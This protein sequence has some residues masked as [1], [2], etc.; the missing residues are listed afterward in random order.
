MASDLLLSLRLGPVL[1]E[2]VPGPVVDAL[3]EVQVTEGLGQPGG[4]QLTFSTGKDSMVTRELLPSGALDP[5]ARVQVVLTVRGRST[6][7]MDGVITRHELAPSSVPGAGRLTVTG[8]DVSRMMDVI[9]FSGLPYVGMPPEARVALICAKYVL[10][11]LVPVIVPSVFI[12]TPNPLD[13]IP[14]Q[15]GS[16]LSYVKQ[17]AAQVGYQFYVTPGPVPGVNFAVWAPPD[18]LGPPQPPLFVDADAATN[19]ESL[20][21]SFDGFSATQ[22]VVLI[23]ERTTKFPIPVPV[24]SVTPLNPAMGRRQPLPL[25]VAPIRGLAKATPLQAA[26]I[27][28]ARAADSYDVISGQ[29]GLDVLRYG[30]PLRPRSPVDVC[31]TGPDYDGTYFIKSV[32]HQVRRGSY[33]QQFQLIRNAFVPRQPAAGGLGSLLPTTLPTRPGGLP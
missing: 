30:Q 9:D 13:S 21:F 2:P 4:F 23:Q 15:Q 1:A 5:P 11:G 12:D 6:V 22:Y 8:E 25:R 20:S 32:T 19:V 17:L 10:Y 29:G 18:R 27:A 7:L 28:L 14:R 16:D 24:P 26:G 3:Q 31:G 33:T